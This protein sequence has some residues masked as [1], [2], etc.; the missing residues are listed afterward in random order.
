MFELMLLWKILMQECIMA[1]RKSP[2]F[3]LN[4]SWASLLLR[5]SS[6]FFG[7]YLSAF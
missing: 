5:C 1:K 3:S 2:E 7:I 4:G 6:V